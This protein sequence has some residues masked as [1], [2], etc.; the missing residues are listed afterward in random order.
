MGARS[1]QAVWLPDWK[2][3]L[4]WTPSFPPAGVDFS[5]P[6]ARHR[7]IAVQLRISGQFR[8]RI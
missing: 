6:G 7:L 1:M 8:Q 2:F 3:R 4:C 5:D